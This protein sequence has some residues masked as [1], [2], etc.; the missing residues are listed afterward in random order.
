VKC[1]LPVEEP[2]RSA[3][4]RQAALDRVL[5]SPQFRRSPRASELLAYLCHQA[6]AASQ[7]GMTEHQIA[8]DIYGRK[9]GDHPSEDTI[10]R[11]QVSQLRKKL[12]YYCLSEGRLDPLVIAIPA[13]SYIPEFQTRQERPQLA[14]RDWKRAAPYALLALSLIACAFLGYRNYSLRS[15]S[16]STPNLNQLWTGLFLHTRPIQV[17]LSDSSLMN[18]S[19]ILGR[20]VT[21]EDYRDPM[22]PGRFL[23]QNSSGP[24]L[25]LATQVSGHAYTTTHDANAAW[26]IARLSRQYALAT[27]LIPA[28]DFRMVPQLDTDLILLGHPRSNPWMELF[29]DRMNFRYRCCQDGPTRLINTSPLPG[30]SAEYRLEHPRVGYCVLAYQPRPIG[31]GNALLLLGTD[32]SSIEACISLVSEEPHAAE[33][34]RRIRTPATGPL[35][36]FE[37]LVKVKLLTDVTPGFE[38][39]T[40]RTSPAK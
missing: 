10:V 15:A 28:R 9:P 8:L 2:I 19:D 33:L 39:V 3:D 12:Q 38:F 14:L 1:S 22:F 26:H 23:E 18:L 21:L 4:P 17:V 35:P 11:V 24:A 37:V 29:E 36:Y 34:I 5:A 30:E 27:S 20:R 6:M 31:S 7:S 32:M 25:S 40:Q 16:P 13:G